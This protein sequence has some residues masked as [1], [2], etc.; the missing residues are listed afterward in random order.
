V[1]TEAVNRCLA[2]NSGAIN[3]DDYRGVPALIVYRWLPQR[4]LCLIVKVDQ[5]EALAASRAFGETL[6]LISILVLLAA[7]VLAA[8]LARSITRPVHQLVRGTQ[9]IGRGNLAYRIAVGGTDELGQL[10]AA[11]NEMAASLRGSLGETARG[12]RMLFALSQAAQAVQRAQTSDEIYRAVGQAITGLGCHALVLDLSE[13]QKRLTLAHHT[14]ESGV[15]RA[16]ERLV[17]LSA[18][19]FHFEV[20]P[21]SLHQQV[22]AAGHPRFF[23]RAEETIADSLPYLARPLVGRITALLGIEQIIYAPLTAAGK[24]IGL[25]EVVGKGLTAADVPVIGT[26][27]NQTAIALENVRLYQETLAWAAELERR[28]ATQTAQIQYQASLV[29]NVSDAIIGADMQFNVE[30]WNA[31]AEALYGWTAAEVIG[32]SFAKF[33]QNEY[34]TSSREETIRTVTEQGSWKGE[35]TQNRRDGTRFPVLAS[36]SLV[37]DARGQP[38]GFVAVNRDI[39]E[40]KQAEDRLKALA[41]ELERSNRDLEQFAYVASH[42]LQEPLRMVASYTQLLAQRYE[43]QFDDRAKTYIYYAVDGATRMQRLINDLL[44][45][46]RVN[47]QGK[48]PEPVDAQTVLSEALHNLSAAIAE[49]QALVAHEALPTVRADPS[50]L[51][52]V[53]QNLIANGIKFH[54]EGPPQIHVTAH[55]LGSEWRFAVQDNGI[56]IDPKYASRLFVLFQRLHTR[57]EYPGTGIGLAVC[58]RIVERHGGKIW[59]ESEPGKG[60]TFYFTLPK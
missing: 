27:A 40:R 38:T 1:H 6:L 43:A 33:V 41:T 55:D 22:V 60:T 36:V 23:D 10:A 46:S 3:A 17:G 18:Q 52:Q 21:G 4:E 58:K 53:F 13:D 57:Q 2:R 20:K 12:H 39:T 49:S 29:A 25:L 47:T 54:R 26:F 34:V 31:A 51:R 28:V 50:Q 56:G 5:A 32:Q 15:M 45:F 19:G 8:W 59:F 11:F 35:V 14:V 16:G 9:E 48:P 30:S 42:D 24:T 44:A 37:K 7:A